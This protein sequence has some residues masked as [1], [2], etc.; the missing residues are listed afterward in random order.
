MV[1]S[2]ILI[3][4]FILGFV[5]FGF[6][7]PVY[8]PSNLSGSSLRSWLKSN[9]YDGEHFTLSYTNARRKMYNFIDN[10]NNKIEDVYGGYQKSWNYGGSGTNPQPINCEHTVPQSFF[11]S[12]S[13]MRSDIHHLFPVTSNVNSSRGNNPFGE[14]DDNLTDKWWENNSSQTSIPSSGIDDYSES[15]SGLF[16]PRESQKGDVARAVFY[17][18]TMY[19]TQAGPISMVGDIDVLYQWHLQDPVDSKEANRNDKIE[20]YQG[21]RNPYVDHADLIAKAW[22]LSSP[23]SS[24]LF[25][26]EYVEGSSYNKAIEIV[27]LTG[28]TVNL[29]NYKLKKQTNGAGSWNSGYS[30]S[31]NLGNGDVFVVANSSAS[32]SLSSRADVLT[33]SSSVTF[34]GNDPVGLFYNNTLIDIVGNFG[35]GSSS[36]AANVTLRRKTSITAPNTSYTT[37]EWD[38]Y[39]SNTFGDVGSYGSSKTLWVVNSTSVLEDV[40]I[41]PNPFQDWLHIEAPSGMDNDITVELMDLTGRIME[42]HELSSGEVLDLEES[43]LSAGVYL[44]RVGDGATFQTSKLVKR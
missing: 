21:N 41:Y 23:S 1:K 42:T 3:W 22:N 19:P 5:S 13:P 8:P 36:F 43:Q 4:V 15:V 26:S 11:G 17:F 10:Q 20:Q 18:Y 28:G 14:I 25:I 32:S 24:Q 16:E 37:S 6:S 34:N 7:Q 29:S 33:S 35:G 44:V 12:S 38:S 40:K 9:W 30:L 31:G 27:N 39:S 2:R